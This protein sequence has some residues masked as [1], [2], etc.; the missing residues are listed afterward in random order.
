MKAWNLLDRP[1]Y[2]GLTRRQLQTLYLVAATGLAALVPI[3]FFTGY[4]IQAELG[5]GRRDLDVFLGARA[6]ALSQRIDSQIEHQLVAL[7]AL[8]ALP[9]LDQ[10]VDRF[11]IAARRVSAAMPQWSDLSLVDTEGRVVFRTG[12]ADPTVDQALV[13]RVVA[14]KKA[15]IETTTANGAELSRILLYEPVVRGEAVTHIFVLRFDAEDIRAI[16]SQSTGQ[17]LT[18]LLLDRRGRVLARSGT[19]EDTTDPDLERAVANAPA[20]LVRHVSPDGEALMTAF[21]RSSLTGWT[22]L[23][24]ISRNRSEHLFSR[25]VWA[26]LAAGTLSLLL[27]GILAVFVTHNFMERRVSDERLAATRAL[28]ELDARLLATSQDALSDQRRAASER[29]VLLREVYHRVKNNLQ[30]VQSLLRLGSRDLT[31]MQREPFENAVRRIGAMARVHTLLYNSPDLASIDFKDYLDELLRE[32]AEGFGAEERAIAS[33]LRSASMRLPLDTAVPLAFIAVEILTNAFKH[34][35]PPGRPGRITVDVEHHGDR[36][37]L[38]IED[39]GVG[40]VMEPGARRALGLTIVRKLVQQI[41]GELEEPAQ[42]S[43]SFVVRFPVGAAAPLQTSDA[44]R[45]PDLVSS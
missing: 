13:G 3:I 24:S 22:S 33:E 42:G 23:V 38:R 35:F 6:Y 27:A 10:D 45:T 5:K 41:G 26:T 9:S 37:M 31:P 30:I 12:R 19:G 44:A 17:D 34:A 36:A 4:W 16:L 39:D 7:H 28:G 29:E 14:E 25:P 8:A 20:G 40:I 18:S 1:T 21:S 15:L 32:L 2:F 43:S 11:E